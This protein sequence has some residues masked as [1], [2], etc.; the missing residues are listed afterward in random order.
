[1]DETANETATETVDAA[2]IM[3]IT[4]HEIDAALAALDC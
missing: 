1:M 3:D 2:G 4:D